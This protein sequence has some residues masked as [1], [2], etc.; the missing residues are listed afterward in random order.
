ME[1]YEPMKVLGEGSF[2]KVYLM[3]HKTTRELV[4][5]KVIKLKNLPKK[6]QI[7]CRNEV[8][9]LRR[10]RHP[11]IVGYHDSFLYKNCLCIIMEYCDAGDLGGRVNKARGRLFPEG[12][13]LTWFVQ[14][15]LGL[16]YMHSNHTLHRDIKTQN[17]FILSSGRVVLGDLGIS[18][19]MEGTMDFASTCIGTPYYMSPEIFQN[20]PYNN[21]SDVWALGCVL[22]ELT[23]LKHAFDASSINGLAYKIIKGR[24]PAP[25]SRY[26]R[27]LRG[28]IKDLLGTNPKARPDI[29]QVLRKSFVK[30]RVREFVA[31][32]TLESLGAGLGASLASLHRQLEDLG[33]ADLCPASP[34]SSGDGGHTS[35]SS[36][37]RRGSVGSSSHRG[38]G[39]NDRSA[40]EV[41]RH[42]QKRLLEAEEEKRMAAE[43]ALQRLQDQA[44]HRSSHSGGVGILRGLGGRR[45]SRSPG[46]TINNTAVTGGGGSSTGEWREETGGASDYVGRVRT[47]STNSPSPQSSPVASGERAS[48]P[49]AASGAAAVTAT[50]DSAAAAA[51]AAAGEASSGGNSNDGGGT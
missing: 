42:R 20:K 27:Q 39:G 47:P 21:K 43:S 50:A 51:A 13:I 19:V 15:A 16:H 34:G 9:V 11:N 3:K 18:K 4:C 41:A 8:E 33:M 6:E 5:T 12:K 29:E 48:S 23:T 49:R 25:D 32:V 30:Q 36:S 14:V 17:I 38:R 46:S 26:S 44:G 45:G 7:A 35:T 10:M 37:S 24:Y 40:E 2:G 22:Y 28:L 31:D 1:I